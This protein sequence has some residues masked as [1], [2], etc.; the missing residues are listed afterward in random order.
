MRRLAL[1]IIAIS[2]AGCSRAPDDAVSD[3][4]TNA[5]GVAFTYDYHFRLP[6]AA[7]ADAQDAHARACEALT[8]SRCRITGMTYRVDDAGVAGA[9][10][11]VDL[12]APIA[13]R[14]GREGVRTVEAAGGALVG[15]EING[16]DAMPAQVE[17]ASAAATGADDR[18]RFER[19][20]ARPG[21]PAAERAELRAQ[22][23][24][25]TDRTRAAAAS[26]A[27]ARASVSMT[28]MTFAYQAGRGTG[29][30]AR[31]SDAGGTL[32]ASTATT[33]GLALTAVA[34][35]GPPALLVLA[36]FLLWH[37]LGRRL[38]HR[39]LGAHRAE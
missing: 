27:A 21:L 2:M 1:V 5:A 32:A 19:D 15:A 30:G 9:T 6:S 8:P 13:R 22:L 20:L 3:V 35:L 25:A 24:A 37:H 14:F 11:A 36:L 23:A 7:I 28:P 26:A 10:L 4:A 12:A 39:L 29:I 34:A 17:G 16:T 33:L 38:W 31:V 18:A